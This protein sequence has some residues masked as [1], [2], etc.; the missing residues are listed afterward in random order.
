M[1]LSLL[2]PTVEEAQGEPWGQGP[3]SDRDSEPKGLGEPG[4]KGDT[5]GKERRR[6]R[7]RREGGA[8]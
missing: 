8:Q 2:N 5:G 4:P 6:R 1:A 3:K 7:R